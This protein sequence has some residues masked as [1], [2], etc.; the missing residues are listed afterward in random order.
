VTAEACVQRADEAMY[1]AKN[2][3]CTSALSIEGGCAFACGTI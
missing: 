2:N 3:G 1:E